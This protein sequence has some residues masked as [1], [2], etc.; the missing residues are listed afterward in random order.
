MEDLK[1]FEFMTCME[2]V[3][4]LDK[5][6]KHYDM[7]IDELESVISVVKAVKKYCGFDFVRKYCDALLEMLEQAID[8]KAK[9]LR[10]LIEKSRYD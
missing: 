6:T 8:R 7:S 2:T 1:Y 5:L 10:D 4:S 9:E 3:V